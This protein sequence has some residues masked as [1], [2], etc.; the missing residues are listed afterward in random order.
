MPSSHLPPVIA[1]LSARLS[2]IGFERTRR[3]LAALALSV[4]ISIYLLVS[5]NAPEGFARVFVALS[6]CYGVAF[7]AVV[8]EYFW[9]RWFATGLAWSGVMIAIAGVVAVGWL[10]QLVI[11]GVLHLFVIVALMGEKMAA[12]YDLQA[13][14]RE[15]YKMDDFGVARLQKTITRSAASLPS[16]IIWALAPKEEGMAFAALALA[17]TGVWGLTRLRSWGV[18][19][20]GAAGVL[21]AAGGDVGRFLCSPLCGTFLPRQGVAGL[22]PGASLFFAAFS[23]TLAFVLLAAAVI[24]FAGAIARYL[25]R[26]A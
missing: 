25:R 23:P 4:F 24:P 11:F 9:G 8:A 2:Q 19:S 17:V 13:A 14:W 15:R 6:F 7:F 16:L 3:A 26:P 12:R 18:L 5:L 10:P 1:A 20:L 22:T 21:V